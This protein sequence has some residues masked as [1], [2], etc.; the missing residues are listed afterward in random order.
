LPHLIGYGF[1]FFTL[2]FSGI[3]V[4]GHTGVW[5]WKQG[6]QQMRNWAVC[7]LRIMFNWLKQW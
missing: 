3:F 7:T 1:T 2:I 6:K 5:R 4:V